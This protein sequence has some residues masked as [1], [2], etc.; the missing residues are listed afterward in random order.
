MAGAV[1]LAVLALCDAAYSGDWSRIE[2][3]TKDQE[4]SLQQIFNSLGLFHLSCTAIAIKIVF[5]KGLNKVAYPVKV[6]EQKLAGPVLDCKCHP[7]I[8]SACADCC[9]LPALSGEW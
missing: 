6:R 5:D 2:V 4:A 9:S 8:W 1:A 7:E 3:L